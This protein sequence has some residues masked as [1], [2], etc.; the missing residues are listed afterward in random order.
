MILLRRSLFFF[1]WSIAASSVYAQSLHTSADSIGVER[2]FRNMLHSYFSWQ[3]DDAALSA[4]NLVGRYHDPGHLLYLK[5]WISMESADYLGSLE[6]ATEGTTIQDDYFSAFYDLLSLNFYH[7]MAVGTFSMELDRRAPEE[8]DLFKVNVLH[9]PDPEDQY[10]QLGITLMQRGVDSSAFIT[11]QQALRL[12][13]DYGETHRVLAEMAADRGDFL[14]AAV[15]YALLISGDETSPHIPHF[16]LKLLNS[17]LRATDPE[18]RPTLATEIP[19]SL[20]ESFFEACTKET[21][22]LSVALFDELCSTPSFVQGFRL[23]AL[24]ATNHPVTV[25]EREEMR[26]WR[27]NLNDSLRSAYFEQHGLE[28]RGD[29]SSESDS[30]SQGRDAYHDSTPRPANYQ[31]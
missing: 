12:R 13:F 2:E 23:A 7:N 4:R 19:L 22:K 9:G 8:V 21:D 1:I 20:V 29:L 15:A 17:L 18:S 26:L 11:L 6:A 3:R 5:A 27:E 25:G 14:S 16:R 24:E 10:L 31:K 30:S 28:D